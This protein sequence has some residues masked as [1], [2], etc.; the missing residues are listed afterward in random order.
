MPTVT[1]RKLRKNKTMTSQT[2]KFNKNLYSPK[3]IKEAVK[4]YKAA[5][6]EK[7]S[8]KVK[9]GRDYAEVA[10]TSQTEIEEDLLNEFSNYILFLNLK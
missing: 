8:F 1:L 7:V 2:L 4:E 5:Y 3:S 6:G 10:I 9:P